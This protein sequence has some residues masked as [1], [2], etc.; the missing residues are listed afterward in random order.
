MFCFHITLCLAASAAVGI[1]GAALILT[2]S[3]NIFTLPPPARCDEAEA[4]V[5]ILGAALIFT[6]ALVIFTLPPPA[7]SDKT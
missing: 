1:F 3:L 6:G 7:Y 5:G 2:G 4:A